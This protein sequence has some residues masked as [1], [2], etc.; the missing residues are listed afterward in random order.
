MPNEKPESGQELSGAELPKPVYQETSGDSK[1]SVPVPSKAEPTLSAS[2]IEALVDKKLQS[3]KDSRW[4]NLEKQY[5]ALSDYKRVLD[6][7]K[8]G[9]DPDKVYDSLERQHLIREVETLK[10]AS[11]RQVSGREPNAAYEEAVGLIKSA[12]L[13]NDPKVRELLGGSYKDTSEMLV[14][15]SKAVI[16]KNQSQPSGASVVQ[17]NYSSPN[18]PGE[19]E[20]TQ[21][22]ITEMNAARGKGFAAGDAIKAKYRD[23]GVPVDTVSFSV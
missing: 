12:G 1:T 21:E 17:P 6:A 14:A 3:Q 11:P 13:E 15:I 2:E 20:L 9:E 22:Y 19:S 4:A 23:L 16:S 5:G 7:V 10:A 18:E 8:A